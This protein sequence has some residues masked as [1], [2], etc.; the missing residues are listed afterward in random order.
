M[1]DKF[2]YPLT[3]AQKRRLNRL[4]TNNRRR[5]RSKGC[6][7]VEPVDF[8]AVLEWQGY[9][10]CICNDLMNPALPPDHPKSISVEHRTALA[11]GGPHAPGNV[12][13]AHLSCNVVKGNR[14]DTEKAAKIKRQSG[15]T[16]QYAR[17]QRAKAAGKHRPIGNPGFSKSHT[18]KMDG[19]VVRR[20][21]P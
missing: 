12:F 9:R 1:T 16:G 14:E 3:R 2:V 19:T 21:R 17:R 20:L 6:G 4:E 7:T 13:G 18:R 10:C 11:C 15:A 8:I 5:A